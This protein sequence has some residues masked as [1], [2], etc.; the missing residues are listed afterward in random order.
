M[1]VY[2][3]S[4]EQDM[5]WEDRESDVIEEW[6]AW[7]LTWESVEMFYVSEPGRFKP[8]EAGGQNRRLETKHPTTPPGR[9]DN[10]L[11]KTVRTV[12]II[13]IVGSG[14]GKEI[15]IRRSCV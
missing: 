8:L 4:N 15:C 9:Y 6:K 7:K 10:Y 3:N 12:L 5:K 2:E 14:K 11:I 1:C 13:D